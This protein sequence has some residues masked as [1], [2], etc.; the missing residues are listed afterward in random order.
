ME[1]KLGS[2]TS[3]DERRLSYCQINPEEPGNP[4]LGPDVQLK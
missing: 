2:I 3:D 4:R 1:K